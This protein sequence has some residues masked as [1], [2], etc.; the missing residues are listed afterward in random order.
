MAPCSDSTCIP[1]TW[2]TLGND[3][4]GATEGEVGEFKTPPRGS[5]KDDVSQPGKGAR[6]SCPGR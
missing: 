6:L 3:S 4:F 5:S 1:G 2:G